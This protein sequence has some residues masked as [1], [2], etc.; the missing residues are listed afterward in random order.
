MARKA[1]PSLQ[2]WV[3]FSPPATSSSVAPFSLPATGLPILRF[4][5]S[6]E[7]GAT[8]KVANESQIGERPSV[9]LIPNEFLDPTSSEAQNRHR[10][11][12]L[13]PADFHSPFAHAL[14][15]DPEVPEQLQIELSLAG[16]LILRPL[17]SA[18][19]KG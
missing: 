6:G 10:R 3:R 14:R 1:Q 19:D 15:I 9:P 13:R 11:H 4:E 18:I 2:T 16:R 7:W 8:F 5:H 12:H 17:K